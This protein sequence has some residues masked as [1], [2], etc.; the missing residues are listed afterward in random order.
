MSSRELYVVD[1]QVNYTRITI[2]THHRILI[3]RRLPVGKDGV[4]EP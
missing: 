3:A 4:G 2:V 1:D